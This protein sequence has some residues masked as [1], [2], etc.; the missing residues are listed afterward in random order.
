MGEIL[1]D[2]GQWGTPVRFD[3]NGR[4]NMFVLAT[5]VNHA[6]EPEFEITHVFWA[7]E[8]PFDDRPDNREI[9]NPVD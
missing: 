3:R 6:G 2:A 1:A 8:N 4:P 5:G 9:I 7:P